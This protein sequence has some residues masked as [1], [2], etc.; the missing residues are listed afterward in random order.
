MPNNSNI[1]LFKSPQSTTVKLPS[2]AIS[3]PYLLSHD[4]LLA[5][6]KHSYVPAAEVIHGKVK[7][8]RYCFAF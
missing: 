8:L 2:H 1:S 6:M 7:T 3:L 5:N 4:D